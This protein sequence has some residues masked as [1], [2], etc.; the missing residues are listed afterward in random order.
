MGHLC[1]IKWI[2]FDVGNVLLDE[3]DWLE[4]FHDYLFLGLNREFPHVTR[5]E[6]DTIREMARK[7]PNKTVANYVVDYFLPDPERS[8]SFRAQS[9]RRSAAYYYDHSRPAEGMVEVLEKLKPDFNLGV[10]ANQAVEVHA[11]M[12]KHGLTPYFPLQIYDCD[13][14]FAKP[15]LRLY[16]EAIKRAGCRP[17]EAAMI[18]D[19]LDNDIV[20][21][22]ALG[23]WTIRLRAFGDYSRREPLG[24]EEVPDVTVL[25]VRNIPA[26][27]EEICRLAAKKDISG[28]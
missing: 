3:S 2:F 27:V 5:E 11:W 20:P 15:D 13:L 25:K 16:R 18:G 23:M 28:R 7:F 12:D 14:G 4:G 22:K 1:K 8:A 21:A 10:I 6:F 17:E 24:P 9:Y 19:R 26:A